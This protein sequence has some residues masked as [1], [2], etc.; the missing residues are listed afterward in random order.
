MGC[1]CKV[2]QQI[3]N[4][5]KLGVEHNRKNIMAVV[6]NTFIFVAI[7][8][9]VPIMAI[10]LGFMAISGKHIHIDKLVKRV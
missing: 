5:N 7:I 8:P 2:S 6:E 9:F 3:T 4:L 1:N 10:Y